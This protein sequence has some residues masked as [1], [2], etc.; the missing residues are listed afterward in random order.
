MNKMRNPL[1]IIVTESQNILAEKHRKHYQEK[2]EKFLNRL[3]TENIKHT[4][5]IVPGLCTYDV[6]W[7]EKKI[8]QNFYSKTEIIKFSAPCNLNKRIVD[9]EQQLY[10]ILNSQK[11]PKPIDIYGYSI[12]A[13]DLSV[14]LAKNIAWIDKINR[15]NLIDP[16]IMTMD[17]NLIGKTI[18][19][20]L[21]PLVEKQKDYLRDF[22][23][24]SL[25]FEK[26]GRPIIIIFLD[27][28]QELITWVRSF[29]VLDVISDRKIK[30]FINYNNLSVETY[31]IGGIHSSLHSPE[32]TLFAVYKTIF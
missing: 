12:A 32:I 21:R 14:I 30:L 29:A 5:L 27:K 31:K 26:K 19:K 16:Y 8:F 4:A 22:K 18:K 1:S 24:I 23:K 9:I 25:E 6:H 3:L 10:Q 20:P 15:I 11:H 2:I 13:R 7:T 17:D 28:H